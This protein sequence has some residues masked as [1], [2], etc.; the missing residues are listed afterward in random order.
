MPRSRNM[1]GWFIK[2]SVHKPI[3]IIQFLSKMFNITSKYFSVFN[4]KSLAS[5]VAHITMDFLTCYSCSYYNSM[6]RF[7]SFMKE[8]PLVWKPVHWF[9]KQI[10]GLVSTWYI[11]GYT[12]STLTVCLHSSHFLIWTKIAPMQ[13]IKTGIII[14]LVILP[15]NI[16]QNKNKFFMR[17]AHH[18]LFYSRQ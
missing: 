11:T 9:A 2:T 7:N 12:C 3:K 10:N 8:V 14:N 1:I 17:S 15:T 5:W 13:M 4:S 6:L 16:L 18:T